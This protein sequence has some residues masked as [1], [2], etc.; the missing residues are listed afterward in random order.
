MANDDIEARHIEQA[1]TIAGH[2]D[3][4]EELV[5]HIHEHM[6]ELT[7]G[8]AP[9]IWVQAQS[10]TGCTIALM[11]SEHF[12]PANLGC[13]KISLRY[14]PNMMSAE[15]SLA[16][17]VIEEMERDFSGKYLVV[18]EGAVPTG[19]GEEFC[20]FGL[21]GTTKELMGRSFPGD[22]TIFDW[23]VE[24]IPGAE[25]VLAVGNCAAYGGIPTM[26]SEVTG[27]TSATDVVEAIDS[28]KPVI[29]VAGCPPHP[30]WIMGTLIDLLLWVGEHK[31]APVLDD[32]LRLKTFYEGKVHD[33]CQRR[34]AFEAKRFLESW[35]DCGPEEDRCLLKMGCRGPSTH[36][37]CPS[38][39]WNRSTNW[40][41]GVNA[42]CHG[43]T[44]PD[45]YDKLPHMK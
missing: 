5:P 11:N 32:R 6:D 23:L 29:N 18:L 20:T 44:E 9:V 15:G 43:C 42:P 4:P 7:E 35:N 37:D 16:T 38:R 26:V 41:V 36:A 13:S 31:K 12:N 17:G 39:E 10:C 45:F 25:A 27:A 33:I 1:R 22:R 14:Q 24:L 2:L 3:L 8:V 40:C 34:P 21:T 28:S 19:L 30:D